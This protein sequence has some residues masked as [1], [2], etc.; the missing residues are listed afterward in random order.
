MPAEK[1]DVIGAIRD[2]QHEVERLVS[3]MPESAWSSQVYEQGWNAKQLLCHMASTSGVARFLIGMA[4]AP[5]SGGMGA[6]FDIDAF[7]AQAVSERQDKP[8][9]EVLEEVRANCRRDIESVENAPYD[10]LGQHFR[11]P[12]GVEGSLGDVIVASIDGHLMMHVGDLAKAV[13]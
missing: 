12:W 10:L 2:A 8:V 6:G 11:A 4:K 1:D 3:S 7:N 9:V 5:G 13:S